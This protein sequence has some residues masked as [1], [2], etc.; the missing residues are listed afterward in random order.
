MRWTAGSSWATS[1]AS[2]SM[3]QPSEPSSESVDVEA[4][5][6]EVAV[7]VAAVSFAELEASE[8]GVAA[9]APL[10]VKLASAPAA[11]IRAIASDSVSQATDV[12]GLFTSGRAT[13]IVPVEHLV[14]SHLPLT[15]IPKSCPTQDG[16]L[17]ADTSAQ[18]AVSRW[19]RGPSK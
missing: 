19:M 18:L 16:A 6:D 13:Q 2:R 17:A 14:I 3:S 10:P 4:G 8:D 5:A 9:L 11:C 12:P 15:H 1:L 7:A